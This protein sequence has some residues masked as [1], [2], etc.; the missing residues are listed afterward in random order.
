MLRE[1]GKGQESIAE[2]ERGLARF[3]GDPVIHNQ[4]ASGLLRAG[5]PEEARSHLLA[6][7]LELVR[8]NGRHL[9]RPYVDPIINLG[10]CFLDLRSFDVAEKNFGLAASLLSGLTPGEQLITRTAFPEFGWLHLY[11]G[12]FCEAVEHILTVSRFRG[13]N[14]R[15]RSWAVLAAFLAGTPE[16]WAADLTTLFRPEEEFDLGDA[17]CIVL[18]AFLSDRER[19]RSLLKLLTGDLKERIAAVERET[20]VPIFPGQGVLSTT[21]RSLLLRSLDH[22]ITGGKHDGLTG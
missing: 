21:A 5:R 10:L 12:E 17:A 20:G 22:S 4:L 6:A 18:L 7:T 13:P 11:R 15:Y 14:S 8:S 19:R 16:K 9:D 3:P 1:Q 2:L